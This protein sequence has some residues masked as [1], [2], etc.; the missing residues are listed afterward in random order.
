MSVTSSAAESPLADPPA[1]SLP[2]E[3]TEFATQT[4]GRRLRNDRPHLRLV[5]PLRPERASRGLFAVVV[6]IVLALGLIV[7][8]LINTSIA[9]TAFVVSEL[10]SQQRELARTEASLTQAIAAAAAPPVLESKARALGMVPA[11]RPVFLTIPSGKVRGK[12]KPAPGDRTRTVNLAG[13]LTATLI[14]PL[15]VDGRGEELPPAQRRQ[16]GDG[17]V[18][19]D[20]AAEPTGDAATQ[21][22]RRNEERQALRQ[23]ATTD[24]AV[25]VGPGGPRGG[26]V[27]GAELGQAGQ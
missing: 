11:T 15:P 8:L 7:M 18:L 3:S 22:A 16:V 20:A 12:A 27:D 25:L 10:Q 9:Q 5:A 14:D 21:Q 17:A 2:S 4:A 23:T 26:E 6:T 13:S 24:G 19:V 1:L